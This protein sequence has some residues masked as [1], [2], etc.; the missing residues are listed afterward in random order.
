MGEIFFHVCATQKT[1]LP[2]IYPLKQKVKTW[3]FGVLN[4]KWR[5]KSQVPSYVLEVS[6]LWKTHH[7]ETMNADT[8][9]VHHVHNCC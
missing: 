8:G 1:Y 4:T 7:H 2:P 5:F 6:L 3:Y 9:I